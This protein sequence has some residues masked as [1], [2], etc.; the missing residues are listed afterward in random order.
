[1]PK[2]LHVEPGTG[3]D[4][5]MATE[6]NQF[7]AEAH[8]ESQEITD[9]SQESQVSSEATSVVQSVDN[10]PLHEDTATNEYGSAAA[11][12]VVMDNNEKNISE[13]LSQNQI[14][15][16]ASE[17]V[18]LGPVGVSEADL[19]QHQPPQQEHQQQQVEPI[20]ITEE[21]INA[22]L[23]ALVEAGEHL[24]EGLYTCIKRFSIDLL[25]VITKIVAINF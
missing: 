12:V 20:M 13:Q 22:A 24:P 3:Q 2:H 10:L 7:N 15:L 4:V 14:N 9:G 8:P 18:G 23:Q 11:P 16:R 19:M 21:Q 6:S 5:G 25:V 17:M 1:M